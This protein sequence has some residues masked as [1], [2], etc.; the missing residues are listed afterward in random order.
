MSV[1]YLWMDSSGLGK[2]KQMA[3]HDIGWYL[4]DP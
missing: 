1:G 3:F 4:S 2:N